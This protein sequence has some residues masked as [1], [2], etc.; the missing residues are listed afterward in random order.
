VIAV[1]GASGFVGRALVARLGGQHT[2]RAIL[3]RETALAGAS[4]IRLADGNSWSPETFQGCT[5][6]CHLAGRAHIYRKSP[7][8]ARLFD[9]GNRGLAIAAAGA[10]IEA[11]VKHFVHVSS[12]AVHGD[13][14]AE[15]IREDS[16]LAPTTAYGASKLA[17]EKELAALFRGA[18]TTLTIIRPPMIYGPACPG[19]FPRLIRLVRSN[20]P[21]PLASVTRRRSFIHI[22]NLVDFLATV[23]PRQGSIETYLAGDGSDFTLPELIRAIGQEFGTRTL[24]LPFPPSLLLAAGQLAGRGREIGSLTRGMEVDWSKARAHFDW[25]PA[26]EPRRALQETLA[27]FHAADPVPSAGQ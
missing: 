1:T 2:V 13:H 15:A 26:V 14:A 3:R 22:G 23:L 9:E 24:L 20:L 27:W 10:A 17:A 7:D 21:L 11:G 5:A 6:V 4:E 16:P 12:I 19:N 18:G 8:E 25:Q